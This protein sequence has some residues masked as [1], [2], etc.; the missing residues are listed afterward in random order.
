MSL[1]AN[2]VTASTI[3]INYNY[4]ETENLFG[5]DVVADYTIDVSD[6]SFTNN[7]GVL[8]EGYDALRAVYLV[9][10]LTARIGTDEFINGRVTNMS[11]PSA[12][13]AG[14][15]EVR[16]TIEES[17]TLINEG[18][19]QYIP[20]AHWLSSFQENYSFSRSEDSYSYT[21]NVSIQ[22]KQDAGNQFLAK[23]HAFLRNFY[24]GFRPNFG[25]QTDGI[26]EDGRINAGFKPLITETYDLIGLSVSLAENFESSTIID[27][28]SKKQSYNISITEEGFKD[29]KY[30]LEIKALKEPLEHIAFEAAKSIIDEIV[31]ANDAEFKKP[32]SLEKGINKDG[33]LITINLTFTNDPK[34]QNQETLYTASKT[35][36]GIYFDYNVSSSFAGDGKTK[37]EKR[38]ASKA[39]WTTFIGECEAKLQALFPEA[40]SI[41]E[42]SRAT[43]FE[44]ED[45]KISESTEFTDDPAYDSSSLPAGIIKK[46]ETLGINEQVKRTTKFLDLK[47]LREKLIADAKLTIG[48][49]TLTIEVVPFRSRG[50]FFG[51]EYLET[52]DPLDAGEYASNDVISIDSANGATNRVIS[53]SYR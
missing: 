44:K 45:A 35:K 43:T 18:Y 49:G 22:Y 53:Y 41:F 7:E 25:Y 9:P 26:S 6:V 40:T 10:S 15:V 28:Y 46:K 32:I 21:R 29:K 4:L 16:V 36:R 34:R 19:S 52:L 37:A 39:I 17:K 51:Q 8:I 2:T 30:N 31:T 50:L 12:S 24:Y 33:G 1:L 27:N 48:E 20:S 47:D 3:K 23:A 42:K 13:Q 38:L 11:L 14:K 5:Y